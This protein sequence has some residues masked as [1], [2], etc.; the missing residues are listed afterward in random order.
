MHATMARTAHYSLSSREGPQA[1]LQRTN[2]HECIG[3]SS[4]RRPADTCREFGGHR[5]DF[6]WE[7]AQKTG[8]SPLVPVLALA[9]N[10]RVWHSSRMSRRVAAAF[11]VALCMCVSAPSHAADGAPVITNA[12]ASGTQLTVRWTSPSA[13]AY[14]VQSSCDAGI[15]W[16]NEPTLD[17][18]SDVWSFVTARNATTCLV[19]VGAVEASGDIL[20]SDIAQPTST[21]FTAPTSITVTATG[22]ATEVTWSSSANAAHFIVYASHDEGATWVQVATADST[23]RHVMLHG[24]DVG[25][26]VR[27]AAID[28]NGTIALSDTQRGLTKAAAQAVRDVDD[29]QHPTL[30]SRSTL[31]IALT[32][33]LALAVMFALGLMTGRRSRRDDFTD[34]PAADINQQDHSR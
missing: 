8:P 24:I 19:R 28:A 13:S 33:L 1:S 7:S 30:A 16:I 20:Y 26:P 29:Q 17:R 15:T 34:F 9:W 2:R 18:K 6:V 22:E 11:G 27:V 10:R 25:T 12:I 3:V 32:S 5:A 23:A 14:V 21:A 31:Q 4:A